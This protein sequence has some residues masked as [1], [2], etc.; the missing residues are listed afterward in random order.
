MY[1]VKFW[2]L[3]RAEPDFVGMTFCLIYK[4]V[5]SV[6]LILSSY[7]IFQMVRSVI[8][9]LLFARLWMPGKFEFCL[10]LFLADETFKAHCIWNCV[11][12]FQVLVQR[13]QHL[14]CFSTKVAWVWAILELQVRLC[15]LKRNHFVSCKVFAGE[16]DLFQGLA[17]LLALHRG[18]I[19][20]KLWFWCEKFIPPR[21][22]R[23]FF[24]LALFRMSMR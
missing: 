9:M 17:K 7:H 2:I 24:S 5:Q 14:V 12:F 6:A 22:R 11:G 20:G 21:R 10:K 13:T 15:W 19:W 8:S 1:S 4:Q 3:G 23:S 18:W 16:D